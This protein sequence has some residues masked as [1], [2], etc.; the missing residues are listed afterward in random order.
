[1]P[2]VRIVIAM[3]LELLN[4]VNS[5]RKESDAWTRIKAI[6]TFK[7]QRKIPATA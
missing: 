1:M 4:K 6:R 2:D 5:L 3:P 7:I